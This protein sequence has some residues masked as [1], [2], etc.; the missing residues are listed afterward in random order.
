MG[1]NLEAAKYDVF[2][3]YS[4]RDMGSVQPVVD[5]LRAEGYSCWMDVNGIE[6]GDEFR[7]KLVDAIERSCIVVF[8]SSADSN[9]SKWTRRE[10]SVA[11]E[12]HKPI[13]PVR[14]DHAPYSNAI[15]LIL[16]GVDYID[17]QAVELRMAATG[18]LLRSVKEKTEDVLLGHTGMKGLTL[19]GGVS[20]RFRWCPPGTFMMGSP[21]TE[22]GHA[23]DEILHRVTLTKGFWMGETPVTQ[24]QWEAVMG[25]NPS[26]CR[27]VDHPVEGVSWHDCMDFIRKVNEQQKCA[28]RLP[29]E[30]EWEY[31]CRAETNGPFGGNGVLCEMGWYND[32]S[33]GEMQPS[34]SSHPVKKK[35]PNKWGLYDMH[36]NVWEWCSD[37]YG[38]YS[39]ESVTD[40]IGP[41][42]GKL[43]IRR[44]GSWQDEAMA[45]RS[46]YRL[47]FSPESRHS[48]LGFRVAFDADA[49]EE[50]E[51]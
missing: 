48:L 34:R 9:V 29:T 8:F 27:G 13:I 7:S 33:Y 36:G 23:Q 30:A 42:E 15:K 32:D 38:A 47:V 2:I 35:E 21:Q 1:E 4:R 40:P 26:V 46:A 11:D 41:P 31:A 24:R 12:C 16:A 18:R 17:F 3:S 28:L 10:L 20:M 51:I 6:S 43:K 50:K 49:Y 22:E 39:A 37:W 44:G 5:R 25:D 45:C 19:P 14:L